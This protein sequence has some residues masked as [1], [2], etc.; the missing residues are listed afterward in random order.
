L[1]FRGFISNEDWNQIKIRPTANYTFSKKFTGGF[2]VALFTT[3]NVGAGNVNEFR[4]HQ[5]LNFR[6]PDLN[7]L[8]LFYRVRVEER[9]F[10]YQE[11]PNDSD[12]RLRL[13]VGAQSKDFHIF[14]LKNSF[15]LQVLFEGFQSFSNLDPSEVFINRTRTYFALGHWFSNDVRFEFHFIRQRSRLYAEDGF[16][17]TQNIF[18]LRLFHN[19]DFKKKEIPH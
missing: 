15:Y 8:R 18:R 7:I 19:I 9:F 1:G 16:I 2:A 3:F 6:W 17:T 5:E 10:K 11:L 12:I 13:L 4:M 14:K